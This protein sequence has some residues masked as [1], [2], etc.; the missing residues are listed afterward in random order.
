[1]TVAP[2]GKEVKQ[3]LSVCATLLQTQI[4]TIKQVSEIIGILMSNFPRAQYGLLHYRQLAITL[5]QAIQHHPQRF[6][7]VRRINIGLGKIFGTSKTGG[8]GGETDPFG[9]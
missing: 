7:P 1:M 4:P 3:I 6:T 2:T 5:K 9:S 8:G